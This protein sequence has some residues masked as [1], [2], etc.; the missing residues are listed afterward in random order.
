VVDP[1]RERNRRREDITAQINDL[2][3]ERLTK[4]GSAKGKLTAAI[5]VLEKQRAALDKEV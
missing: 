1:V 5:K 3:A 2:E 4:S